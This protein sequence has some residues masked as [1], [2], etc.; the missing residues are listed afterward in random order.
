MNQGQR[1]VVVAGAALFATALGCT[2][3][4]AH[5]PMGGAVPATAWHGVLSGLA[6]P[7]IGIDHLAFLL[8][9][10]L[11]A[12]WSRVRGVGS[13][14]LALLFTLAGAGGTWLR[15]SGWSLPLVECGV[16]ASLLVL[17]ALALLRTRP[18]EA[19]WRALAVAAGAAH[20]LAF[21]EAVVGA[22]ATPLLAYLAGLAMI[23]T[24][25]LV[26]AFGAGCRIQRS[27][28]HVLAASRRLLGAAAAAAGVWALV[29]P[30]S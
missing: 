21:G 23:Q 16:A 17:A 8:G 30:I 14:G 20:G 9:A 15:A 6:H 11:L 29:V 22:E 12:A 25:L 19:V 26:S 1:R 13:V 7:I 24:A 5:H 27:R 4:L 3:A 2:P 10:A 18:G 28:P